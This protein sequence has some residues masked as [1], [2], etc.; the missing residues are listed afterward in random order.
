MNSSDHLFDIAI[1]LLIP[2]FVTVTRKTCAPSLLSRQGSAK[3]FF[4]LGI[5]GL[6]YIILVFAI[7]LKVA[8]LS[9]NYSIT[10]SVKINAIFAFIMFLSTASVL[11][12]NGK[13]K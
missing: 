13:R 11:L 5:S 6:I 3:L 10:E 8:F 12:I 9:N 4:D 1:T 7:D 2:L